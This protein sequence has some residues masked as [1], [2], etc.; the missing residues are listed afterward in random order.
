MQALVEKH[1]RLLFKTITDSVILRV[2]K[3]RSGLVLSTGSSREREI[4]LR[5][6]GI[7]EKVRIKMI[8]AGVVPYRSKKNYFSVILYRL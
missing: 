7:C 2:Q 8:V 1:V 3:L 6:M 4:C 5:W